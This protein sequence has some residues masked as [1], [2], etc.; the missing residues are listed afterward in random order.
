MAMRSATPSSAAWAER[1]W[2]VRLAV[3]AAPPDVL[4]AHFWMSGLAAGVVVIVAWF[5]LYGWVLSR[6]LPMMRE[7]SR[8]MSEMRS[9]LTGK[10]VDSYTNI[11]TVKLFARTRD[12]DEFV[13][14][15]VD[16][17]ARERGENIAVAQHD[18][19]R[20]QQQ[21]VTAY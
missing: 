17:V 8:N 6:F 20:A 19:T 11:L 2:A 7:R 18:V 10:I 12:E 9:V 15:A 13:R 3:A 21:L 4:H 5:A 14:D 16:D 1:F